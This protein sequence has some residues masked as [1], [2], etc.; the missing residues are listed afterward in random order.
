MLG[1]AAVFAAGLAILTSFGLAGAGAASAA[2]SRQL[3]ITDGSTWTLEVNGGGCQLDVFS[4]TG[5]FR[6]PEIGFG[7]DGGTWSGGGS[8]LTMV[9]KRGYDAGLKFNGTFSKSP[10]AEYVGDM[11][12]IGAGFTGEM[13]KGAVPGC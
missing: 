6:S 5:H 12:G 8:T 9:W 10:L 13:V 4:A 3:H 11:G 7:G 2:A 1:K